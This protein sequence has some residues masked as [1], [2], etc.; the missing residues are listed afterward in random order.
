MLA[1][2]AGALMTPIFFV[3]PFVGLSAVIKALIVV[4]LGGMG[5]IAGALVGGLILGMVESFGF[6]Y[7]GGFAE[8]IGFIIIMFVLLLR[9]TGI[10]GHDE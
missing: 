9:P 8:V 7:I 10:M 2:L 3:S 6:T 5:S 4:V 1:G